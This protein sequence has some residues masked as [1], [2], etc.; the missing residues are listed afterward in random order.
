MVT[1]TD[2][3]QIAVTAAY[4]V[5]LEI[6]R[7]LGQY[8][9]KMVLIGGWVPQFLFQNKNEWHSGSI[10]IDLALDHKGINDETYQG[11]KGLLLERNYKEGKQPF[12]FHRTVNIDGTDVT[13]QIDLL[14]GEYEGTGKSHRHQRVQA[15][16]TRKARGC[17]LAFENPIAVTIEGYLPGGAKD[18]AAIRVASIVPFLIMKAIVL[19][20]RM[21]EKDA[22]DIYYCLRQYSDRLHELVAEFRPH[23]K[24]RL[25]QEGLTKLAKNFA[26]EEHI[27]SKFVSAF[28]EITDEDDRIQM[29]RDAFER[30]NYLLRELGV[31]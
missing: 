22:Y 23:L 6:S 4:S 20:D 17:D 3:N 21:K 28:E 7:I 25:I 31:I 5:L 19:D 15:L 11:I 14:S 8:R 12:I 16:H 24:N 10:D 18:S 2:Y 13:V 30:V 1:K 29:E 27:G 26:S 9:D